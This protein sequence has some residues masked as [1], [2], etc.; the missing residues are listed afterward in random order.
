VKEMEGI[1]ALLWFLGISGVF[2]LIFLIRRKYPKQTELA[3]E[4]ADPIIDAARVIAPQF[5]EVEEQRESV[6]ENLKMLGYAV[7]SINHKKKEIDEQLGPD[8]SIEERHKAYKNAAIDLS[9]DLL[10]EKGATP[11]ILSEKAVDTA[12][13]YFIDALKFL[14]VED[15]PVT[16]VPI[17]SGN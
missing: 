6:E 12:I 17:N 5:I 14:H 1:T 4:L 13:D 7:N 10:I 9:R 11:D 3:L 2:A 15:E 8:V 16:Y